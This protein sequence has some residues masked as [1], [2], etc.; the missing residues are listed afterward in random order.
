MVKVQ[1]FQMNNQ[2][3]VREDG[4]RA[5]SILSGTVSFQELG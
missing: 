4:Q 5:Y 2:K 1:M 3:E